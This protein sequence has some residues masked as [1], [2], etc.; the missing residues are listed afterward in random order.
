MW[1]HMRVS[2]RQLEPFFPCGRCKSAH[3]PSGPN[4][5]WNGPPAAARTSSARLNSNPRSLSSSFDT[6]ATAGTTSWRRRPPVMASLVAGLGFR[7]HR[8]MG[9]GA[10][11]CLAAGPL[12]C[13]L[14]A[15]ANARRYG[16]A[17]EVGTSVPYAL[18]L[19]L[20]WAISLFT[21]RNRIT[22]GG[23][24]QLRFTL[25]CFNFLPLY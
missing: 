18:G 24:T 22:V 9:R 12:T 13:H 14:L 25:F 2:A 15:P 3:A 1:R 20:V 5:P 10:R 19:V 6:P 21:S 11:P 16:R 8:G 23:A 17:L 4:G 7:R